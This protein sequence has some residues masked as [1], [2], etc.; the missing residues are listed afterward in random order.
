MDCP[1][2]A[3]LPVNQMGQLVMYDFYTVC[4]TSNPDAVSLDHE[5]E[6][7]TNKCFVLPG[8]K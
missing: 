4:K 3:T 1:V 5:A 7:N 8:G 6:W 2:Y